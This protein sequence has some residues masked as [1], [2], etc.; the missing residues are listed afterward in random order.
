V[1][2][3]P[4]IQLVKPGIVFGNLVSAA[5]GF[6]LASRGHIDAGLF[7]AAA[8]GL[9]LVVAGACVFNNVIDADIDAKMARTKA[10]AMVRGDVGTIA[11]LSYGTALTAGGLTLLAFAVNPLTAVLAAAGFAV[12]AG[13]YSLWLKRRSSH[14]TL[15]GSLSGAVPPIV[16]YCAVTG[17]LDAGAGLLFLMFALWQ[18][19]HSYAIAIFR[20]NDY[21]AAGIPVQPV[22]L[23]VAAAKR[24]IVYYILAFILAA[25]MLTFVGYT[26]YAYLAVAGISGAYWLSMAVSGYKAVDDRVWAK[27]VFVCS[28]YTIMALC[29]MMAV[30]FYGSFF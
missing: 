9:S 7:L 24:H 3:R 2:F 4:Y 30:D 17:R 6:L 27:R 28:I 29:V 13:L 5:G 10:R 1:A 21:A 14:G 23:G 8:S 15:V 25:V 18:M 22:K 26:G 11:A 16:G 12:Y 19:P 20:F